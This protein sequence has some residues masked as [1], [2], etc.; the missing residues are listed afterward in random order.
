MSEFRQ[1]PMTGVWTLVAPDRRDRPRDFQRARE[2]DADVGECPL[3]AGHEDSTPPSKQEARLHGTE[4]WSIRVVDNKF[5]AL[6]APGDQYGPDEL[7]APAPYRAV[8][9]FGGHEVVVETPTHDEGL[10]DYHAG[11]LRLLVDVYI[12]RLEV[13]RLDGRV[14]HTLVFRNWGKAAGAS[15]A[16]AH[17]QVAA[18]PRVPEAVIS[19]MGNFSTHHSSTGRCLLCDA[20]A[21]D[22]AGGRTV[23]ADGPIVLQSPFAAA[24]PYALRITSRECAATVTSLDDESRDSLARILG[25]TARLLREHLHDPAFNLILHVAPYRLT[26]MAVLPYHWHIDVVPRM[27]GLAGFELGS[28]EFINV[29]DPDDAAESLRSLVHRLSSGL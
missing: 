22:D 25:L 10:A 19:E 16:H 7:D 4:G 28:G 26:E 23:H 27:S 17:S 6:S 24:T 18:L 12:D 13:W 8:T 11:H 9:G 20:V 29:V 2:W 21:S 3:C 14:A 15:L 5:P 1:D